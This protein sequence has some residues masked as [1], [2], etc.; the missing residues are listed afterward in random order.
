MTVSPLAYWHAFATHTLGLEQSPVTL[1]C[2]Q[3]PATR[4][5]PVAPQTV[6]GGLLSAMQ[7]VPVAAGVKLGESGEPVHTG[8]VSQT[9]FEV[10]RSVGS[11]TEV[12]PALPLHT[13]FWQSPGVWSDAGATVLPG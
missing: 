2:T 3:V 5:L 12:T 11:S 7:L 9:V 4:G 10:G 8:F 6:F 1:H 13:I